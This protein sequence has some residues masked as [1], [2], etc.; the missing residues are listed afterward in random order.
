MA[1]ILNEHLESE[2]QLGI[3]EIQEDYDNLLH[4]L[5]L[6]PEELE[7][8]ENF[9]N[10]ERK[11]EWLSVRVLLNEMTERELGITYDG[12]RKP[13]VKGNYYNISISH[14][15]DLTAIL[16]SQKKRVGIDME[17]MSH[18]I[19]RIAHR[20]INSDEIITEDPELNT[21]H[22][23]IH[24]CAKEALYKI[25]DKQDIQLKENITIEPFFPKPQGSLTGWVRNRLRNDLFVLEYMKIDNYVV[26]WSSK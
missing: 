20:F 6:L 21:F 25:C 15:K 26:V 9:R 18:R 16:L 14:S 19:S 1:L 24:W 17:Y 7:I 2:C 4:R 12:N 8:V 13:Y 22:M 23:Y 10:Y 3:W 11:L 5:V